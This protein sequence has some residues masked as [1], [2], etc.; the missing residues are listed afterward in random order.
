MTIPITVLVACSIVAPMAA[1]AAAAAEQQA[2]RAAHAATP[3]RPRLL[4]LTDIGG[5]PDDQQSMVRLMLYTNEF[6]IEGLIASAS[7]TPGELKERVTRPQLIREIIEAYGKV[8]PNLVKHAEGYPAAE[9]LLAKVK[10]GNP[11][12]GREAVGEGKDTEGSNWIIAAIDKPGSRRLNISIWG[13]QTDLA[14]ALWRVRK[15]SGAD[16]LARFVKRFRV[17]D[18]AD[19]DNIAEWMWEEFPGMFYI[20]ATA[21]KGADKRLGAF[22]GMYLGGD[23]A[24]TSRDWIEKNV[25]QDHGP[26][27]ALYPTKT[28][29]APN[30]HG[31]MKEGDTPSWF[32]F[33]PNGLSDPD[34]PE[35]GSWGGRFELDSTLGGGRSRIY[36]DAPDAVDGKKPDPRAAVWRWRPAFQA[37]FQARLDWCVGADPAKTP[38]APTLIVNGDA[39]RAPLMMKA[40]AGQEVK[41]TIGQGENRLEVPG[42]VRCFVY[43]EAGTYRGDTIQLDVGPDGRTARFMAPDVTEPKTVHVVVELRGESPPTPAM[44]R[45]V[46]VTVQPKRK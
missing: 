19:Q 5:D 11:H 28:W 16:G 34:H 30:P 15:D 31:V 40:A 25:R 27:G 12:R 41:L 45:R 20:L 8:R 22:R 42:P 14:Q 38:H 13:G 24:L 6:E 39:G 46:V 17:Y 43:P 37:D 4:V 29:T 32:Y 1:A 3:D 23:E 10:S 33:L 21:P 7:G 36:R 35:W 26:L 18:I 44:Y 2:S 9:E